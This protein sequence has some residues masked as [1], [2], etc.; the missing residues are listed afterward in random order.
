MCVMHFRRKVT[1]NF[2]NCRCEPELMSDQS[3]RDIM[4]N[5]NLHQTLRS[6]PHFVEPGASKG[7][8]NVTL[9]SKEGK[10]VYLNALTEGI[11]GCLAWD[12]H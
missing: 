3:V 7:H 11:G 2:E 8:K 4:E 1:Y 12:R 6:Q 10:H 5:I 9:V